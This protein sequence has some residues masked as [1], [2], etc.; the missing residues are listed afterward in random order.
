MGAYFFSAV[1]GRLTH[2]RIEAQVS[3]YWS[4]DM[5][6]LSWVLVCI[7]GVLS[8]G[9]RSLNRIWVSHKDQDRFDVLLI[10]AQA[11]YDR[12]QFDAAVEPAQAAYSLNPNSEKAAQI[13]AFSKLGQ[14]GLSVTSV[15]KLLLNMKGSK[16]LSSF[17]VLLEK[18]VHLTDQDLLDMST[19]KAVSTNAYFVGLDLYLPKKPGD[20][21]NTGDPRGKIKLLRTANEVV[22]IMCPFVSSELRGNG[23]RYQCKDTHGSEIHESQTLLLYALGHLAEAIAFNAL[24]FYSS[25][26]DAAVSSDPV[27]ASNLLARVNKIT[28]IKSVKLG[29]ETAVVGAISELSAAY[30]LILD[31]SEGSM[32]SEI[33]V[34]FNQV[35]RAFTKIAG[36]P[37]AVITSINST[38]DKLTT[39]QQEAGG[40][41]TQAAAYQKQV[42]EKFSNVLKNAGSTITQALANNTGPKAQENIESVCASL[43]T[44]LGTTVTLPAECK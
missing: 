38:L 35:A 15:V 17:L 30:A 44:I 13:L 6:R 27:A 4:K 26:T 8:C 24:L 37:D 16:D 7:W 10:K 28:K 20:Y 39:T 29:E 43:K 22:A 14:I 41:I 40:S 5:M 18:L 21:K 9:D 23:S 11:Y 31:P 32:E 3:F 12:G 42:V 25:S 19:E 34:D 36:M 33:I 1:G 2:G